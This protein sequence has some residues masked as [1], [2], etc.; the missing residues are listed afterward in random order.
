M[1]EN[2]YTAEER[3]EYS[4]LYKDLFLVNE[5]NI[6]NVK[7]WLNYFKR[8]HIPVKYNNDCL[9]A[10]ILEQ[11]GHSATFTANTIRCMV[12]FHFAKMWDLFEPV[13]H[14]FLTSKR[15]SYFSY[16]WN[17]YHGYT[18]GD[19]YI[20]MA[21]AHMWNVK[22]TIMSAEEVPKKTGHNNDSYADIVVIYNNWVQDETHYV[23]TSMLMFCLQ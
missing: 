3:M 7:K 14:C 8:K 15:Q 13:M 19:E 10:A 20:A 6:A 23:A 9:F 18:F 16:I 21:I 2:L 11:V 4:A 12:A 17:V 22:I 1:L 5:D